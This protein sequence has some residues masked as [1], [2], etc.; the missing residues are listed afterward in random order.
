MR[1]KIVIIVAIILTV[2]LLL[3]GIKQVAGKK[4]Y[5]TKVFPLKNVQLSKA[6]RLQAQ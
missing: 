1:K 6:L 4:V 2:V 3:L 5:T